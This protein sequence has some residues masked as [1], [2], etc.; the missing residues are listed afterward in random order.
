MC[1]LDLGLDSVDGVKAMLF[2]PT[3]NLGLA[4]VKWEGGIRFTQRVNVE[5]G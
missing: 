1:Q 2:E 3:F 4:K 5:G